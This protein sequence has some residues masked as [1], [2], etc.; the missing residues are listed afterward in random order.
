MK[1]KRRRKS[2][3]AGEGRWDYLVFDAQ[4]RRLFVTRESRVIVLDAD[5]GK[6]VGEIP[7][8]PGVHGVALASDLGR[9]FTSNGRG[10]SAT[11]FDL[12]TLKV[13]GTVKTG[14]NPDAIVYEPT[15][16]RIFTMNGRSHDATVIDGAEGKAVG[17]IE[18]GGK[19]EFAVADGSGRLFVN[20]EEKSEIAVLDAKELTV[21]ARWPLAPGEEFAPASAPTT[22]QPRPSPS[23]LPD[24]FRIIVVGK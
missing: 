2:D 19:P 4:A 21:T 1:C 9:G 23:T 3:P 14:E 7:D 18:L 8:T 13:I 6:S 12:K 10:G 11:I 17:R 20:L 22:D 15:T 5:T 16:K 24:S